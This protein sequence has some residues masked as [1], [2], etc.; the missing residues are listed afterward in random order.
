MNFQGR[1]YR[2]HDPRW[3]FLPISGEG[4]SITG[5]RFN[6]KGKPTLYLSLAPNTAIA[7]VTQGLPYR[8]EPM[9]LVAY[10]VDCDPIADLTT[11][12]GLKKYGVALA[13]LS[14]AWLQL[15]REGKPVPSHTVV[16]QLAKDGFVGIKVRSFAPGLNETHHNLVLW[17]WGDELPSRVIPY[18]PEGKLP[19]NQESWKRP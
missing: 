14:C 3:S 6:P 10:D 4:A 11:D 18:D 7:E 15:S 2:A 8:F 17:A 5:G 1:C 13:D 19:I 12:E 9:L 16:E